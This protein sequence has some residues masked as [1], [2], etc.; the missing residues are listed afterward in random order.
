MFALIFQALLRFFGVGGIAANPPPIDSLP[1]SP[2]FQRL[3]DQAEALKKAPPPEPMKWSEAV[4]ILARLAGQR[5]ASEA[6]PPE[7]RVKLARAALPATVQQYL[8]VLEVLGRAFPKA[9]AEGEADFQKRIRELAL[10]DVHTWLAGL[11]SGKPVTIP[12][13]ITDVLIQRAANSLGQSQPQVMPEGRRPDFV[14]NAEMQM[15][16]VDLA[17]RF[18]VFPRVIGRGEMPLIE[19]PNSPRRFHRLTVELSNWEFRLGYAGRFFE[20]PLIPNTGHDADDAAAEL[21]PQDITKQV[22]P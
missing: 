9:G 14:A 17:T 12:P 3:L 2:M 10:M 16:V 15:H 8:Y 22:K 6:A 13:Y 7:W 18:C 1:Y 4:D 5:P 20:P 21:A 19:V 11:Y